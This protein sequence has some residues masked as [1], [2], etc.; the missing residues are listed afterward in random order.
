VAF[1]ASIDP[2]NFDARVLMLC[3]R[4]GRAGVEAGSKE[5]GTQQM[6]LVTTDREGEA[7][8][9]RQAIGFWMFIEGARPYKPVRVYVSFDS[10]AQIDQSQ[11]RGL[12]AA[13]DIFK[14]HR[15]MIEA[16]ASDKFDAGYLD[17]G[18]YGGRPILT[19]HPENL[20]L[21]VS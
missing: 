3:P 8:T 2:S 20:P 14:R 15:P 10:L 1:G 12:P 11:P 16:A 6:P 5:D 19:L 18:E 9:R 13:L 4:A 21:D 17:D 7:D